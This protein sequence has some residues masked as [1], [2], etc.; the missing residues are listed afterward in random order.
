MPRWKKLLTILVI[1]QVALLTAFYQ[2]RRARPTRSA[3][4]VFARTLAGFDRNGD[5]RL[6]KAEFLSFKG[7]PAVF[8]RYDADHDGLL[9]VQEFRAAF[10][11]ED[12][13]AEDNLEPAPPRPSWP[14]SA[15]VSPR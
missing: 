1:A 10:E 15:S 12:P 14:P 13:L 4:E 8:D 9:D 7:V 3:R 5:G 11:G 2:T 6:S